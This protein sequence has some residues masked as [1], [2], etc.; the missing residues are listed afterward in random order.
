MDSII[1]LL[2]IAHQLHKWAPLFKQ[3]WITTKSSI[4]SVMGNVGFGMG[5][6]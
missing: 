5:Q 2:F 6:T 1:A 4:F 3:L